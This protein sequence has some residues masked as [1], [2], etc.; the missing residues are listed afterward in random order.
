MPAEYVR[1]A[2]V[3]L[4]SALLLN[5]DDELLT[6]RVF[7]K[8]NIKNEVVVARDGADA[9]YTGEIAQAIA[10]DFE[11][12]DGFISADD[13]SIIDFMLVEQGSPL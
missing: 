1:P 9:F 13:Y 2:N 6:L 8:N 12:N 10:A 5:P 3:L 11:A 7:K 4:L